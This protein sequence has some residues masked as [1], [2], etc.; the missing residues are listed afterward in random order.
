MK[1]KMIHI[2]LPNIYDIGKIAQPEI[3][4]KIRVLRALFFVLKSGGG[5]GQ[6][7]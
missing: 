5:L 4:A 7:V 1:G 3:R 2:L 6:K